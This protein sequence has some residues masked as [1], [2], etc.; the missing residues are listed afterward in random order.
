MSNILQ[1][2]GIY[3]LVPFFPSLLFPVQ[4]A[5]SPLKECGYTVLLVTNDFYY[6][7]PHCVQMGESSAQVS[8]ALGWTAADVHHAS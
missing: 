3:R 1:S 5:F 2:M 6:L 7:L 8:T 4:L